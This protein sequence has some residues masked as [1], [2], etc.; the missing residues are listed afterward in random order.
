MK[1]WP[2]AER[3]ETFSSRCKALDR[4]RKIGD[5]FACRFRPFASAFLPFAFLPFCL[6][7]TCLFYL[8]GCLPVRLY[9]PFLPHRLCLSE[10]LRLTER[11]RAFS[12]EFNNDRL[13][14]VA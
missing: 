2:K 5:K 9:Q 1:G 13:S 10:V 4:S 6:P 8:S 11:P 12:F 7:P 14:L 3:Q